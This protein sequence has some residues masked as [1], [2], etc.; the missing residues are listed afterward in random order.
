[1]C[2]DRLTKGTVDRN[3]VGLELIGEI[4]H[5]RTDV[6][7]LSAVDT[8]LGQSIGPGCEDFAWCRGGHHYR[9]EEL[10]GSHDRSDPWCFREPRPG[11]DATR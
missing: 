3:E 4:L 9:A 8:L 10:A 6:P 11:E 1:M 5:L 2:G 7:T